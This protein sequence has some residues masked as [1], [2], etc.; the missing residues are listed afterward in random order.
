VHRNGF[1]NHF[2]NSP[3]AAREPAIAEIENTAGGG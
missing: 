2:F 1:V 3:D